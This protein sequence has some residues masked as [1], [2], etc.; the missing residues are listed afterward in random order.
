MQ[1]TVPFRR[2]SFAFDA[3]TGTPF[4]YRAAADMYY[5]LIAGLAV[6]TK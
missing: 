3:A 1:A 2:Y 6:F 5:G 4:T